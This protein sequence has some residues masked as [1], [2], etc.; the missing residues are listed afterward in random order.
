MAKAAQPRKGA[1]VVHLAAARSAKVIDLAERRN[2]D[3][4]AALYHLSGM[5][6]AGAIVGVA[7]CYLTR[8]GQQVVLRTGEY[9]RS[10]M[11]SQAGFLMQMEE[12][13]MD[14]RP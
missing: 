10:G 1:A 9:R 11:G 5:A 7:I 6:S 3:T 8:S 13:A 4:R 2:E 14:E 12:F